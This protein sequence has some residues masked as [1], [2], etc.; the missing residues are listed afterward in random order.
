M[1]KKRTR[2]RLQLA[3]LFFFIGALYIL[4]LEAVVLVVVVVAGWLVVG[5]SSRR[6]CRDGGVVVGRAIRKADEMSSC[7]RV[8]GGSAFGFEV[9]KK[10][11][12]SSMAHPPR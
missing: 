5:S 6:T 4:I 12:R 3:V 9:E 11:G 2:G 1:V 8:V 10:P 7:S